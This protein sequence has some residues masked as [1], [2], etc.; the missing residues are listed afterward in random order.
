MEIA[1]IVVHK[2]TN[3]QSYALEEW[4]RLRPLI[5]R[6]YEQE[7]MTRNEIVELLGEHL[8]FHVNEGMLQY[9]LGR[10]NLGKNRTK[11]AAE[12]IV[13]QPSP[14]NIDSHKEVILR[15]ISSYVDQY[16]E[17]EDWTAETVSTDMIGDYLNWT[18]DNPHPLFNVFGYLHVFQLGT[19]RLG[20]EASL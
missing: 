4:T 12:N 1:E 13:T 7:R 8:N 16:F 19:T 20:K 15:H 10:W 18:Y 11:R 5:T 3:D 17:N 14:P 2:R 6:L 9:R